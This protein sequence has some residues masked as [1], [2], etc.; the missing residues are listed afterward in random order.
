[1][2]ESIVNTFYIVERITRKKSFFLVASNQT[3]L[4]HL[5]EAEMRGSQD[6]RDGIHSGSESRK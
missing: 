4:F 5:G 6:R 2:S 3:A 1:M